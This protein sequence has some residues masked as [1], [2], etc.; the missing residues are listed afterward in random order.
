M[1]L[2]TPSRTAWAAAAH[3]AVHQILENGRLFT[4]PLA[5]RILGKEAE[6]V[7]QRAKSQP[8]SRKMRIFI[9]ARTRFAEDALVA[10]VERGVQ[11][12]VILGAGL[13]TYAY[14]SALTGLH[15]FEV[16]HPATQAWKRQRLAEAAIPIPDSL[17]FAP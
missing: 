17:T 15:V 12:L 5:L 6:A 14:R 2:G 9:A 4:D 8:S 1:Q 3:R 7:V 16:D 11:Q 10:A 13:D